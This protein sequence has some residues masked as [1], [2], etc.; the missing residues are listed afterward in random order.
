[1]KTISA[2]VI[3]WVKASSLSSAAFWPT[4]GRPPAPKPRVNLGGQLNY[5]LSFCT[6]KVC[7]SVFAAINSTPATPSSTMWLMALPLPSTNTD[8]F[9]NCTL[10]C[11][12]IKWKC[13]SLFFLLYSSNM[14]PIKPRKRSAIFG[15]FWED[16]LSS[17]GATTFVEADC[18]TQYF[19]LVE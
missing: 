4:S 19:E 12:C 15:L 14:L 8:Y 7:T 16:T 18:S 1:M 11:C 3:A 6:T 9:N 10:S 2:P 5:S 17:L 13:H